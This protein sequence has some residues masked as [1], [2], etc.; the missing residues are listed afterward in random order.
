MSW[1]NADRLCLFG[2]RPQV[3]PGGVLALAVGIIHW[4]LA[5]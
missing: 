5:V 3:T 2:T 1:K 4:H